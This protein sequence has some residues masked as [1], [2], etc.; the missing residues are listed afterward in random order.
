MRQLTDQK[1]KQMNHIR[2]VLDNENVESI[3]DW[4]NMHSITTR[5]TMLFV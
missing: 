4:R 3:K 1:F 2:Q 5:K